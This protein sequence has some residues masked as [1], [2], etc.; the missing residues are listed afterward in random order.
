[1]AE[2]DEF[3]KD[4][5]VLGRHRATFAALVRTVCPSDGLTDDLVEA[6]V[7]E[8]ATFVL[9]LAPWA[10][11]AVR[12]VAAALEHGTRA[13]GGRPFSSLVGKDARIALDRWNRGPFR[14]GI[15]LLRD[16]VLVA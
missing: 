9:V 13:R 4:R 14:M 7:D 1:M 11:R 16:L 10:Q 2:G 12:A 6:T 15:R 5:T 3:S 8:V